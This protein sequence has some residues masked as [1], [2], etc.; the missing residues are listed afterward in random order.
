VRAGRLL[1]ALPLLLVAAA[2]GAGLFLARSL[3]P[4]AESEQSIDFRVE[5]GLSLGAV[6][7]DLEREGLVRHAWA[8]ETLA[9]WRGLSGELRA[10][11]Y[12]LSPHLSS[13]EILER[14]AEGRVRTYRIV[15]PEG[16]TA[17]EIAERL[18]EANLADPGEFLAAVR[19][20]ELVDQLE[21]EG[22]SLEGYLFPETYQLARGLAAADIARA[23]VAQFHAIW[24]EIAPGSEALG[25]SMLETVTLAS[26]VEKETGV[27]EERPLIAAVFHNRLRRGM[28]LETDPTVIYGIPQF[29]GNLRRTDL[30]DAANPYNTYRITGLPPGPIANPGAAALR[31]TVAPVASNYLYFVSRNDGTHEF[32]S[33]YAEHA[34]AVD[35]YQRRGR[36]RPPPQ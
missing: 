32:S 24:P 9:R 6:A 17:V 8:F 22:E 10:G 36:S 30:E 18:E 35:R 21:V 16:L 7:R 33:S 19:S 12:D 3:S 31:A 20:Q 5:P 27:P 34:A 13:G 4:A 23:M 11:E 28:R 26:I 29:D 14:I 2:M 1:L 25:L 15:I